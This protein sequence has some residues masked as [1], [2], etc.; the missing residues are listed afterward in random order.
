MA[1]DRAEDLRRDYRAALLRYVSDGAEE[2][3]ARAYD[4]GRTAVTEHSSVLVLGQIHHEILGEVL[5]TAGP[6]EVAAIVARAGDFL[7]EVLAGVDVVQ[8]SLSHE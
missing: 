1:T 4:L 2:P 3:L 6:Q 5:A 8:R 7:G